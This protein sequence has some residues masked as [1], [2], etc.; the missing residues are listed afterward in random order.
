MKL[1]ENI[2]VREIAGE[3]IL[4]PTG[5]SALKMTGI[6][7]ITEVGAEIWKKLSEGKEEDTIIAELLEDYDVTEEQLRTDYA[8]FLSRLEE[9][10]LLER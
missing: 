6:F 2:I 10:G 3:Y 9:N 5:S 8:E 7:A 1:D 4:I